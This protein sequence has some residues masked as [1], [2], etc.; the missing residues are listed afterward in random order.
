MPIVWHQLRLQEVSHPLTHLSPPPQS[1]V[2]SPPSHSLTHPPHPLAHLTP[3][4]HSLTHPPH[5]HSRTSHH[6]HHPTGG[7]TR[8]CPPCWI[9]RKDWLMSI[10]SKLHT[11]KRKGGT[12]VAKSNKKPNVNKSTTKSSRP[13]SPKRPA[14][15]KT[16]KENHHYSSCI[17]S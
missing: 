17:Q 13:R 3:P 7:N 9:K 4:P 10:T 14:N 12:K 8:Y 5:T 11:R 6:Y 1:L 16:R 2:H 15:A